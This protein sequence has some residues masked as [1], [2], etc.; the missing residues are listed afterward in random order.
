VAYD[1]FKGQVLRFPNTTGA[2]NLDVLLHDGVR[3]VDY[4]HITDPPAS[5]AEF[6]IVGSESIIGINSLGNS[7]NML[8]LV[9]EIG[10]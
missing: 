7:F 9:C 1:I 6:D 10:I 5:P 8:K 3:P 2:A 4:F